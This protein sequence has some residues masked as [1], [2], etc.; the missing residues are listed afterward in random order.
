M[1]W[2][3]YENNEIRKVIYKVISLNEFFLK[4][5]EIWYFMTVKKLIREEHNDRDEVG[6]YTDFSNSL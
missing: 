4:K 3:R 5:I 6:F 1:Y 2:C